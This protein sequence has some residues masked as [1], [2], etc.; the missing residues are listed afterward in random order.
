MTVKDIYI[1][2]L[3]LTLSRE[4]EDQTLEKFVPPIFN[5]TL[6]ETFGANNQVRQKN[7]KAPFE[8]LPYISSLEQD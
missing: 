7:G 4:G 8:T 2:A 1:G 5:I 6:G 3:S